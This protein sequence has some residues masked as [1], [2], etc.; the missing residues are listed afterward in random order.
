MQYKHS[1]KQFDVFLPRGVTLHQWS[2]LWDFS[3]LRNNKH[4][5]KLLYHEG[6]GRYVTKT[7]NIECK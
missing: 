7:V 4:I 3:E 6:Y 2:K 5:E 1:D